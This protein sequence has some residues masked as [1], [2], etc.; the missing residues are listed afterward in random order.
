MK[1][2]RMGV[3]ALMA[4]AATMWPAFGYLQSKPPVKIG[5]V[6]S[7]SG[8]AAVFGI[9]ERDTLNALIKEFGSTMD[10]RRVDFVFCDDKTNPTEAARCVTQLVN[11]EKVV[12][13]IGPGTGSG[14]LAAGPVAQRLQVPLLGPAGT[15]AITDKSNAFYPWVFRIAPNDTAGMDALWRLVV[16]NGAKRVAIVYQEDAYGKF[17][18][19]FAQ[20]LSKDLG[21]TIV[22][23]VGVPYTA[24]DLTP[25]VTRFRNAGV[26]AV[27]MQLS[28]TSLGATFLKAVNEVGLKVPVYANSGLAQKGF[29]D[30][31]GPLGEGVRVLSIGNLPYDPTAP[32]QKLSGILVKNGFKPQGWGEI[33]AANGYMTIKAA[34]GKI[35]GP[36]TGQAMRDTIETLCGFETMTMGKGCFSKDNHDGWGADAVILTTIRS[37]QFRSDAK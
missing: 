12:A 23:S 21:F 16:K 30:A 24:T 8:P 18:A 36:V 31:A 32:E 6:L 28:V 15:V 7:M 29:I 1:T 4:A 19:E 27:F 33:L 3:L 34:L 26:D 10:G 35:E 17:G 22:E 2:I 37:G 5:A 9:P 20:K 14:I 11:D 25:Q 13:I